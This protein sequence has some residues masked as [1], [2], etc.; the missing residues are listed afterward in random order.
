MKRYLFAGIL[1]FTV[2]ILSCNNEKSEPS[3]GTEKNN[4]TLGP[5]PPPPPPVKPPNQNFVRPR[6]FENLKTGDTIHAELVF[7][8][9][10]EGDYAHL[11]FH[12][13]RSTAL[14]F[15]FGHPEENKLNGIAIVLKDDKSG[16]GYKT[17][18]AYVNK[19]F[20]VVAEYK[21]LDG[22]DLNGEPKKY[23]DWRIIDLKQK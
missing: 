8:R 2:A 20:S 15:D 14:E 18:P 16:F 6:A 19:Q 10:E 12:D 13:S 17:N 9:Y 21:N 22:M 1:L 11:I 23:Q 7:L 3:A 4:D 5:P